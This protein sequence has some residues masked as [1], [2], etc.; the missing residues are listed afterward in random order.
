MF[1]ILLSLGVVIVLGGCSSTQYNYKAPYCNTD[2]VTVVQDGDTVS[3]VSV[4]ECTDRPARKTEISRAGIDANCRE[5]FYPEYRYGT[6]VMQRG[7]RCE[8]FSGTTEI[9][10]IDGNNR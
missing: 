4:H 1:K 2:E 6:R 8:T 3:S 7:V 5:F 10:N 9:I